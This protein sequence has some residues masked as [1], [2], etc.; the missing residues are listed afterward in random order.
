MTEEREKLYVCR[1]LESL[2]RM[3]S[4]LG[5]DINDNDHETDFHAAMMKQLGII[6]IGDYQNSKSHRIQFLLLIK[7]I[8]P[9][10]P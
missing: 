8:D 5:N 1:Q 4:A 10:F 3:N 2:D 7:P 6:D 9:S